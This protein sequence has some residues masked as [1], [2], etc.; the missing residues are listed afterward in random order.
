[1]DTNGIIAGLLMVFDVL[2]HYVLLW[3][4][5]MAFDGLIFSHMFWENYVG[6]PVLAKGLCWI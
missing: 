2:G 1:M 5:L 3:W 4:L 6:I